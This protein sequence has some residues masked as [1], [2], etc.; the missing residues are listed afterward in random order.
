VRRSHAS[1]A[2]MSS[3]TGVNRATSIKIL[4]VTIG[5][6]LTVSEHVDNTLSSCASS[7]YALR[8]LR[9]HGL[10]GPA[11]HVITRATT[12][13]RLLYASPAWWGL[14]SAGEVDRIE[15]FLGRVRRAGFLPSDSPKAAIMAESADAALF[16]AIIIDDNHVLRKFFSDRLPGKYNVRPRL[17]P[18]ELTNKNNKNFITRMLYKNIY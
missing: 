5:E 3:I 17:H 8:V 11:L 1:L 6:H 7:I 13:A 14:L 16:A 12:V 18:F 10:P 15:R 4:G 9:A 2:S